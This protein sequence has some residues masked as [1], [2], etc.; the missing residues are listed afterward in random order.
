MSEYCFVSVQNISSYNISGQNNNGQN[1]TSHQNTSGQNI[2]GQNNNGQHTSS[3][4]NTSG[5]NTSGRVSMPG[6]GVRCGPISGDHHHHSR[7][8]VC[9]LTDISFLS[10]FKTELS[11]LD[12]NRQH[13]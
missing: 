6:P 4:P 7:H 5:E 2:S 3:H 11:V 10:Q 9:M 8:S 13:G 1:T 12:Y